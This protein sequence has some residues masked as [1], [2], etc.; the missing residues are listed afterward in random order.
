MPCLGSRSI[1]PKEISNDTNYNQTSWTHYVRPIE[2]SNDP[3]QPTSSAE[4]DYISILVD[5][6]VGV[7]IRRK[8][9]G[10]VPPCMEPISC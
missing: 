6:G 3:W 8:G 7:E 5:F 9:S 10:G 2:S 1:Q 4:F